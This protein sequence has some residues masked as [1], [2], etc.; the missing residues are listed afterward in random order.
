MRSTRNQPFCWQEKKILRLF[1]KNIKGAELTKYIALY[2]GITWLDSDFNG[3]DIKW[4]SVTLSKRTGLS[5]DWVSKALK[6]LVEFKIIKIEE[7]RNEKGHFAGASL[8]FTPEEVDENIE[9][10]EEVEVINKVK[11]VKSKAQSNPRK[12]DTRRT[13]YPLIGAIEDSC[14]LEDNLV[15][16]N[17][18]IHVHVHAL[19]DKGLGINSKG[20][21][22]QDEYELFIE[23]NLFGIS[24][25]KEIQ[26]SI[27][28]MEKKM[29]RDKIESYLLEIYKTGLEQNKSLNEIATLI[30]KGT[31]LAPSPKKI[32]KEK[33]YSD[34]L[35]ETTPEEKVP[36]EETELEKMLVIIQ[37]LEEE[38][39]AE[40]EEKAFK[41]YIKVCGSNTKIQK[42]AFNASKNKQIA[43]Y[44]IKNNI[45]VS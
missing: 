35:E 43:E 34:W 39:K 10:D 17:N 27:K 6:K 7:H 42:L 45:K 9:I 19:F 44:I 13:D 23:K 15:L 33:D 28:K 16:E 30:A 8:I 25:T 22:I 32:K 3:Q 18:K 1:H 36:E 2:T 41:E 40:L 5:K 24:Y 29:E 12:S 38:L 21:F 20:Y 11:S 26:V 14:L 4:Y 31:R 37:N